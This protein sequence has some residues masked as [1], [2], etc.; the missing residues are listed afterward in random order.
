M[1]EHLNK[2][3]FDLAAIFPF[4]LD[5]FQQKAIASLDAGKSVVVCAPTGS[6]KTLVGEYA[7]Y[8]ALSRGK[9]VF[10]TTPLKALSNQKYRDFQEQFGQANSKQV[11]LLTGD[12]IINPDAAVVIMT[13]EIFRNMLYET[14]IG[15]LGTSLEKVEAVILDECH[16]ISDRYRGTVW[17]E[18]IIYCPPSIQLVALS[19]TIGNPEELTDWIE[20]VR[21]RAG[22]NKGKSLDIAHCQLINSDFRPVPLRF[23]FSSKKGLFPLLNQK[24]TQI[25]TKL[26]ATA[27]QKSSQRRR[28]KQKECPSIIQIVKQLREKDMLP[29]IYII[30]SRRGCEKAAE[31]LDSLMLVEPEEAQQIENLLLHFFLA[32]NLDLQ[33]KILE[34]FPSYDPSLTQLLQEYIAANPGSQEQ[35]WQYLNAHPNQKYLLF[36]CLAEKS[37]IARIDQI[38]PL[39][40][41]I[42]THHA[43]ILPA[44]KE[45]VEKLF[46]VGLVKIVF[47]T[48]TLA[49][50]INMPARTTVIS[51]LSKRTD[52]GHS[53]LTPSEFL[54]IAGRAGRR[55]KDQVGYVV[56]LQTPFEGAKE[57]AYLATSQ[58]EPLRS[59]FTPSY[60]MVLNLLQKHSINESKALLE[61][62]FAEYLVQKKL[63]PEQQ[64]IAQ[65]TTELAKLDVE[66]ASIE[67][68]Q[69]ASYEKLR[70]RIKEEQRLLDILQQ[71]AADTRKQQIKPLIP[72]LIPGQILGLKGKHIRVSSPLAAVLI[73]KIPGSGQAPNLVCLGIDNNWYIAANADITDI[74]EGSLTPSD[75]ADLSLPNL[76][77]PRLGKWQKGDEN[78][79]IICKQ[80]AN[81]LIPPTSAPEVIEQQQRIEQVQAK[82]DAHPLQQLDNPGRLIK[83]HQKRL[84]LRE[85][86]HKTQLKYQKHKSNQSYYWDE[87]LNLIKVLQ[88]FS[89]L[90]GFEPTLLG[91]AAATIRADNE[92]WLAL[93]FLSGEL[94]SLEPHHL[95]AAVCALIMETPRGDS[96]CDYPPPLEVLEA[97]GVKKR[98]TEKG[99]QTSVLREIRPQLFQVQ[100]RYGVSL[101]VWREYELVGLCQQWALG[102][103]WNELCENTNLDEGDI[104]RILRRTV[105]VLWQIPQIPNV[106]AILVDN[107]KEAVA[108]MKRFPI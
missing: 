79:A 57:A 6:G 19:A 107:A 17:E 28:L 45:L 18:S 8:R 84:L 87:F 34:S 23:Y 69:F 71:Q 5:D 7:I 97:L 95:A 29:A 108:K 101:P 37:Q 52:N 85:T 4:Q 89:A 40:R 54:Q 31:Q 74:N 46:E 30:F 75:I 83:R 2:S 9:R 39:T 36:Q 49:A 43:G 66:L 103:D 27:R 88:E 59:W 56:T 24:Q 80:I 98:P 60:G 10:Y 77:N 73:S 55:G 104:V 96:W 21:I 53:M 13:T 78:T 58:A 61:R 91:Q 81:Y 76:D 93:V 82:L 100:H 65:I 64:A 35:L 32:N 41:G 33:Q 63:G 38:E 48:A 20:Q 106:S 3:E 50:G 42:A 62:S 1:K 15:Q 47:A 90:D 68:G 12:I 94:E 16:Y 22:E 72:N 70:E 99:I 25:N 102:V 105:D 51:A 86:L 11:G 67:I 92:L 26:K 14:P 44:W